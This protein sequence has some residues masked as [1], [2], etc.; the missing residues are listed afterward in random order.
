MNIALIGYGKMGKAIE[1]IAIERGHNIVV[2]IE[3]DEDY[4]FG[5]K[6][7]ACADVAIEFTSPDQAYINCTRC[8]EYNKPVVSGTTGWEEQ[9]KVL[10]NRCIADGQTLF[11][12]TNFSIGVNIF[13]EINKTLSRLMNGQHQYNA[14]M[15]E[16]HHIHK[17]DSPSGTAITLASE[18][19]KESAKYN[20]WIEGESFADETVLPIESIRQGEVPG[21]HSIIYKSPVDEISIRH[22]AYSRDGFALGAVLAAEYAQTHK[23]VLSMKELLNN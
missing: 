6:E 11:H 10:Q 12:T 23:G 7:F 16:I 21:I 19:I 18:L 22:E 4:K 20:S 8:F 3:K 1:K 13:F 2:I 5:E 9:L 15:Q 17:L 14:S